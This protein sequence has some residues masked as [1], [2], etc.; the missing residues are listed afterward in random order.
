VEEVAVSGKTVMSENPVTNHPIMTI[1]KPH[2]YTHTHTHTLSLSLSITLD[3]SQSAA[4]E[5]WH[6]KSAPAIMLPASR[7]HLGTVIK[8]FF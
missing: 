3:S 5:I 7:I 1:R 8:A 2:T 4:S 6:E